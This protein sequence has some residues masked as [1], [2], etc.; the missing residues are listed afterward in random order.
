MSR[1]FVRPW[2]LG[3]AVV[4]LM[5][6]TS[7]TG[8]APAPI[9][10]AQTATLPGQAVFEKN[11][12]IC[13]GTG[14][15]GKLGPP[16]NSLP[17]ELE[18]LPAEAI[19]GGLVELVR[20]GIPGHMPMFLPEQISDDEVLQVTQYLISLN[21]TVPGPSIYEAAAPVTAAAVP[22]RTFYAATG[23]SVGGDFRSFWQR[24]GGLRVFGLPVT[25]E[26]VGVSPEDG[27]PYT[28]QLFE[29]A[30]LELHPANAAGQR[31]QLALLGAEDLR[32]RTHFVNGEEGGPPE[33]GAPAAQRSKVWGTLAP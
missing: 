12:A 28:M 3:M 26:Y 10:V 14:A 16:L 5:L 11:C 8:A 7:L 4:G 29:R 21:G 23:H 15:S 33:G 25:E 22:G 24:Y 6:F 9:P 2:F 20:G 17:P 27:K 32:F 18:N 31:V 1:S 30:R 13:H 19:A